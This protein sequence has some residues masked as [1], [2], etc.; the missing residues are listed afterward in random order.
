MAVKKTK[1]DLTG[2]HSLKKDLKSGE[3]KQLYLFYGEESYLKRYYLSEVKKKLIS[4]E[5]EEFNCHLLQEKELT[6]QI[7]QE[8]V[9]SLPMN[10]QRTMIIV[11]DFDL[12]GAAASVKESLQEVLM[13]LPEY[14]CVIF[15]FERT[16]YE[17]DGR[18][19]FTKFILN[20]AISCHFA[21]QSE[22]DLVNWVGRRFASLDKDISLTLAKELIFYCGNLMDTLVGEIE[23]IGT[24]AKDREITMEDIKAVAT[25]QLDAVVFQMTDALGAKEFDRA[26]GI[27]AQLFQRHEPPIKIFW[28][29][30]QQVRE[31]YGAK[32][33][34]QEG[35]PSSYL[36]EMFGL[37]PYP[38]QLRLKSAKYFSL[39]WCR[40]AV[41]LTE[42]T[43]L[44]L[45][46][47]GRNGQEVLTE[48]VLALA[49]LKV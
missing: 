17:P 10:A 5:F 27:L 46:S 21:T 33:C 42:Q 6:P 23:K 30:G 20:Q 25:A 32:L 47:T 29:V 41:I 44:A 19:K 36:S 7:L 39:E 38:A 18:T 22:T 34:L 31:L 28:S 35:K 16:S 15:L 37:H 2:Y 43:D 4:P 24:Y 13:D 11:H 1:I 26:T 48:Y 8:L 3:L 49:T 40:K 45:K 9:D 12:F 14:C